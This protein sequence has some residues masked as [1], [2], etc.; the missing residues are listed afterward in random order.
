MT[1]L[2]DFASALEQCFRPTRRRGC[3][4]GKGLACG[5]IFWL[6]ALPALVGGLGA[7]AQQSTQTLP[8]PVIGLVNLERIYAESMAWTN[9]R[10]ELERRANRFQ[11]GVRKRQLELEEED[12]QL[13]EQEIA[14]SPE[15]YQRKR[16][17]LVRKS[18]EFD[19]SLAEQRKKLDESSLRANRIIID[20]LQKELLAVSRERG[21]DMFI[22]AN[23]RGSILLVSNRYDVTETAI[24]RLNS[25]LPVFLTSPFDTP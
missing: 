25:A 10:A 4:L 5:A 24:E 12:R 3:R 21:I 16:Q 15:I 23:T 18:R 8:P 2:K 19:A 14:L 7:Q 1:T 22:L 11:E 20:A 6:W 13:R 9:F 17:E